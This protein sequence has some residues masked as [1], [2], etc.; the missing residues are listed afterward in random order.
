MWDTPRQMGARRGTVYRAVLAPVH[1]GLT[2]KGVK[3]F[4]FRRWLGLASAVGVLS[5]AGITGLVTPV[6]AA[7]APSATVGMAGISTAA[8]PNVNIK[9]TPAK[10]SPTKLTVTPKNFT[11]CTKAKVVWTITNKTK[12]GQTISAKSGSGP[13]TKLG[14]I[15]AGQKVGVCSKGPKGAKSTFFIKGS[16]SQLVVTLN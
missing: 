2:A 13:K 11:T 9:G 8:L 7:A 3:L 12:K 4:A 1:G 5:V 15:K 10:W 6:S 16:K 14:T